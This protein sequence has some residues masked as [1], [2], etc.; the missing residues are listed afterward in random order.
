MT[1]QSVLSL[2]AWVQKMV[3]LPR[4]PH[5]VLMSTY[6][7]PLIGTDVKQQHNRK[8]ST[9][10]NISVMRPL[11]NGI[12]TLINR[13][14]FLLCYRSQCSTKSIACS[15]EPLRQQLLLF[16][17]IAT[18]TTAELAFHISRTKGVL[19]GLTSVHCGGQSTHSSSRQ[20]L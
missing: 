1:K 19:G 6:Q 15:K 3:H 13:Y 12:Q 2:H 8:Q 10:Q 20:Q 11:V 4:T 14:C 5:L 18:A 17:F 9:T 7:E 16:P